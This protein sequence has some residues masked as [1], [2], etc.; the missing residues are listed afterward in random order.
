M[1]TPHCLGAFVCIIQFKNVSLRLATVCAGSDKSALNRL[2]AKFNSLYSGKINVTVQSYSE[3]NFEQE[4]GNLINNNVG[5][6]DIIMSHQKGQ[7]QFADYKQI[8]PFNEILEASGIDIKLE[9][10]SNTLAQYSS[11][12]YKDQ[13]FGI[14]CDAQ[15]EIVLY[16]KKIFAKYGDGTMPNTREGVLALMDKV[17]AN[18]SFYPMVWDA[19]LSDKTSWQNYV[20]ATAVIQNGG[21][22]FNEST[23]K[24]DWSSESNLPAFENA[25][26]SIREF[27]VREPKPL[28]TPIGTSASADFLNDEAL[29]YMTCPW[30]VNDIINGYA[31][32]HNLTADVVKSEYI[33]ATSL[34]GWF[35]LD[36]DNENANK[37]FGD[38]HF[39]AM[40]TTVENIT[41]KAAI[42][43]FIKWF[44]Q[45][46]EVAKSWADAGHVS[47]CK[48][49]TENPEYQAYPSVADFMT[50]YY[51][52]ID[53]IVS[54]G[55]NPFAT[56]IR[57]GLGK[58]VNAILDLSSNASRDESLIKQNE[59][60]VNRLISIAMM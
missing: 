57:D 4:V 59:S 7:K 21:T 49:V 30:D 37:L 23:Y 41:K 29:F 46:L 19:G 42:C 22:L 32:K 2:V 18:E 10:Y 43:E 6:P 24:V 45:D 39:F 13:I 26:A 53:D 15:S 28:V 35:A 47:V 33:G 1:R 25:L 16:N 50:K 38:S 34:A 5:A 52:N 14:P 58:C 55:V 27:F 9:Q 36:P 20:M 60:E 51:P 44:T 56:L 40:S 48:I 31:S 12:N 8:Q 17:A 54:M 11:N 3:N